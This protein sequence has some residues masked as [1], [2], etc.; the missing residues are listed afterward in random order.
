MTED[1]MC[2]LSMGKRITGSMC[3]PHEVSLTLEDGSCLVFNRTQHGPFIKRQPPPAEKLS[4]R[5][6][7]A[8][9]R[10]AP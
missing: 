10:R 6:R 5:D 8:G 7:L 4:V 9:R 3:G 2:A 1:R